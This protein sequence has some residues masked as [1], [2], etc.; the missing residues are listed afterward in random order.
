LKY[1]IAKKIDDWSKTHYLDELIKELAKAY[2]KKEILK[3]FQKKI[4]F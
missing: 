2:E 3:Y 1:L 4:V